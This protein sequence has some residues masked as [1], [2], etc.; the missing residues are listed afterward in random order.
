MIDKKKYLLH[1]IVGKPLLYF[2]SLESTNVTAAQMAQ[3]GTEEGTI[4]QADFQLAGRGRLGR[5]W[6]SPSGK[7]LWFSL[8]L[9]P[10]AEPQFGAQ[11]TLLTAVSLVETID[12]F[13][14]L[15]CSIKWPNDLLFGEKK[16][17]GILS[18]MAL[19]EMGNID[20]VIVGIG[21]NVNL[22]RTDFD[23]SVVDKATSI[24]LQT[25]NLFDRSKFLLAFREIFEKHYE[26]WLARGFEC[27][28]ERWLA[29]NCTL[30]KKVKVK[31][32]GKVVF[33]GIAESI[34]SDGSLIIKATDGTRKEFNFGEISI[35]F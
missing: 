28:R 2:D 24:Y 19:D 20:Y 22:T 1:K 26:L 6:D 3:K 25:G 33:A 35:R 14:N 30:G 15:R 32:D 5:K 9:R 13:A 27:V 17:G 31:D 21:L 8:I 7:G 11:L 23:K 4:I 12:I 16:I 34:N 29:Y 10:M 18:E